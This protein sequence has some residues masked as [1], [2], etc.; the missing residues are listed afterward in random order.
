MR[1]RRLTLGIAAAVALSVAAV[2]AQSPSPVADA[3]RKAGAYA[4][5]FTALSMLIGAFIA[6]AAAALGG[7]QRDLH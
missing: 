1:L 4:A 2:A 6:C 3:A 7:Q 5:I